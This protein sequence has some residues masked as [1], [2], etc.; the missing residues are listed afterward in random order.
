MLKKKP[1]DTHFIPIWDCPNCGAE[2]T[3]LSSEGPWVKEGFPEIW[4]FYCPV[5]KAV[6]IEEEQIKGYASPEHLEQMGW[7]RI[8]PSPLEEK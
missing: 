8:K 2:N 6:P 5:C 4:I 1:D 3:P 7:K